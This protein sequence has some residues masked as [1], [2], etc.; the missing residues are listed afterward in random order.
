MIECLTLDKGAI[1]LSISGG[2][3]LFACAR[4]VILYLVLV[5]PRKRPNMNQNFLTGM[6]GSRGGGGRCSRPPPLKDHKKYVFLAIL[7]RMHW[8]IAKLIGQNSML[9]HHRDATE[10]AFKW[11]FAGGPMMARFK[12]Y[13]DHFSTKKKRCQ[14]WTPSDKSF[15][16]REWVNTRTMQPD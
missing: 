9:G 14:S 3:I 5:Q 8:K 2:T 13:F 11:L 7:V 6:C 12:G 1:G 15:W 4:R 10:T 16:I